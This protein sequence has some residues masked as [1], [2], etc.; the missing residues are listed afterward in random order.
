MNYRRGLFRVWIVLSVIW[1]AAALFGGLY[2]PWPP[3]DWYYWSYW[4]KDVEFY[5]LAAAFAP[6]VWVVWTV[7]RWIWTVVRWTVLSLVRWTAKGFGSN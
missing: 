3:Y 1:S 6:W 5:F 2:Y 4:P 7:V